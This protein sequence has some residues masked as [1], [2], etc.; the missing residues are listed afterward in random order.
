MTTDHV[1]FD[2]YRRPDGSVALRNDLLILSISGLTVPIAQR[3][4]MILKGAKVISTAY[5]GGIIAEDAKLRYRMLEGF[6][7]HPNVG[8][9]LVISCNFPEAER[10]RDRIAA[11]GRPVEM[12]VLD[13]FGHDSLRLTDAAVRAGAHFMQ[14]LSAARRS[15]AN[16]SDLCIGVECGRS[17][18]TSGI[19]SNPLLGHVADAVAGSGGRVIAGE[20]MEWFGAEHLLEKRAKT[21]GVMQD[22]QDAINRRIERAAAAGIDLIGTNPGPVNI[23]MGL[24]TLEEKSLGAVRK[25]GSTPLQG[26][27]QQGEAPKGPGVWLMDQPYYSTESLSGFVAA[28]AHMIL[29]TTGPGNNYVSL[30]APTVKVSANADTCANLTEQIDFDASPIL[31]GTMGFAEATQLLLARIADVASG[32]ATFGEILSEGSETISRC[33]ESL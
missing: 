31:T 29:F 22:V 20:T 19:A 23:S 21:P 30:L 33:G 24:S 8:A 16:L 11:S 10:F 3:V 26:L 14:Q 15:P 17:D 32:T 13:A 1:H 7:L 28:G 2:A 25:T 5:T 18:T 9:V 6:A 4:G 27:L 12:L